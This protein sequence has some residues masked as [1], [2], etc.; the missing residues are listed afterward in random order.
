M[1]KFI[2]VKSIKGGS[3]LPLIKP[4][5]DL[6]VNCQTKHYQVGQIV[7]YYQKS[8]FVAHRIIKVRKNQFLLK[9]D[10]RFLSD[11]WFDVK[12]IVG[13]VERIFSSEYEIDLN[14]IRNKTLAYFFVIYSY[15]NQYINYLFKLK[16]LYKISLIKN[17]YR[18][19]ITS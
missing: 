8:K 11:G 6:L 12:I 2:L 19:I 3:M 13:R 18:K 9:G 1:G 4:G 17:I 7:I 16:N 10:N 5:N 15:L 14:T